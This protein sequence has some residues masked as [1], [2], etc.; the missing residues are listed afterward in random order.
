MTLLRIKVFGLAALAAL[1]LTG[2]SGGSDGGASAS[3]APSG[4]VNL[5][6]VKVG[7][8][9]D[10]G[11]LGD[12]SFNDSANRGAER[13]IKELGATVKHVDSKS[14][15][16]FEPNLSAL[17]QQGFDIVFAIGITQET[18]LKAVAA[19]YPKINFAIVDGTVDAPNV[20]CLKFS[21]EEGSFLAGYLAALTSKSTKLGFV[22][23]MDI[24]LIHKFYAGY[25]AG[26]KTANP[27]IEV[28]AP[29]YTGSWDNVDAGK[30]NAAILFGQ[31]AD[32]VYHA[33]GRAGQ[34]VIASAKEQNKLAIGVDS[35]QDGLA[36]GFVLTSMIKKVDE[37]V[38]STIQDVKDGKFSGGTK[39][40]DLK[41]N[42]VGLSEMKYTQDKL[43]KDAMA[44][45]DE[46]KA[47]IISG[48][49]KVPT[50]EEELTAYLG[51]LK[52]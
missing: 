45:V 29:K 46:M 12:G 24:P 26:A 11:G 43:P 13:A 30:S 14:I 23:G 33:A 37:S 19:K 5:K 4:N 52:K 44:K 17:A 50:T 41:S 36:Q 10:S 3:G 20:R 49:I 48:E 16:D 32:I 18:A 42:G 34:G 7:I 25:V 38:F 51:T 21:E 47:K 22:G 1:V 15:K 8:V 28:L 31:G 6:G 39:I 40:Y 2:C 27:A 9:F 35:D